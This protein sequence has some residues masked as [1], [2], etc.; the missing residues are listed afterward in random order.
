MC[1]LVIS[2]ACMH[3][4][5]VIGPFLTCVTNHKHDQSTFF[6]P[7]TVDQSMS[8]EAVPIICAIMT[9]FGRQQQLAL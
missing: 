6:L 5:I 1:K 8:V 2:T 9:L 7:R 4:R 3:M